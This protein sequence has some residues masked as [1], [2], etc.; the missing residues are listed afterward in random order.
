MVPVLREMVDVDMPVEDDLVTCSFLHETEEISFAHLRSLETEAR[1][2]VCFTS[3]FSSFLKSGRFVKS[4]LHAT[5][6]TGH[7]Y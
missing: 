7:Y 2:E 1:R 5:S 3:L 4:A 6:N